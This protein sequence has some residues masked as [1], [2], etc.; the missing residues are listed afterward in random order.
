VQVQPALSNAPPSQNTKADDLLIQLDAPPLEP[1]KQNTQLSPQ[2]QTHLLVQ[3]SESFEPSQSQVPPRSQSPAL[4]HQ[5]HYQPHHQ[6]QT[7][8]LANNSVT[9]G[10]ARLFHQPQPVLLDQSTSFITCAVYPSSNI[11]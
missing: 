10:Q 3:S 9:Q 11:Q 7:A 4:V 6:Q 8:N 1:I 5:P 2:S